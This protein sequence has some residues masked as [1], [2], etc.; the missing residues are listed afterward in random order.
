M[1][2][3]E[4]MWSINAAVLQREALKKHKDD[5]SR[6]NQQLRL[7]LRQ[8]LDAMTVSDDAFNGRHVLLAVYPAPTAAAPPDTSRRHTVIEAVHVAKHSLK[9]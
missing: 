9:D 3:Q 1:S 2:V 7:L 4:V 5:V 6:E 8:H